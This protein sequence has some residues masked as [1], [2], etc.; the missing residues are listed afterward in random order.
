[1]L[2][3][4]ISQKKTFNVKKLVTVSMMIALTVVLMTTPLGT[5]KT[6]VVS[7]TIAHIP[8]IITAIVLGLG[9]GLTV[10]FSLGLVSL[11]M[12]VVSP[13]NV[14]DPFFMNP[15]ISIFPRMLIPL[16]T[17][18]SY[19]LLSKLFGRLKKGTYLSTCISVIIGNLTNTFGVYTM[20]YFIY[21]KQIFEKT[22]KQALN[23]IIAA[24]SATT[25]IKCIGVVI[26]A[27]PIIITLNV[28]M[29]KMRN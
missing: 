29:K 2:K 10:S 28:V 7:L 4:E 25:A 27:V 5:I 16:T 12:A 17:Y 19:K 9:E 21:A 24:I 13:A 14:L 26:I 20:L 8:S 18:F 22:G 23:Y 6:P 1:M 15:L 3:S 11:I